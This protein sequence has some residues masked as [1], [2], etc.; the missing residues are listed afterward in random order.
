MGR[1]ASA[2]RDHPKPCPPRTSVSVSV[3]AAERTLSCPKLEEIRNNKQQ[4]QK[5]NQ[6]QEQEEE[7]EE[8]R[9]KKRNKTQE[10]RK[11]KSL[12]PCERAHE[13]EL[14]ALPGEGGLGLAEVAEAQLL[15]SF[16]AMVA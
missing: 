4:K 8:R 7:E 3:G 2:H 6:K 10:R 9:K 13:I 15:L 16:C 14:K 11:K 1:S 12:L 5:Q